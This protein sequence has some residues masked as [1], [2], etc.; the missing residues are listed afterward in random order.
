MAG[1]AGIEPTSSLLEIAILP[2]ELLLYKLVGLEGIEPPR[3]TVHI[4]Y[5]RPVFYMPLCFVRPLVP[6]LCLFSQQPP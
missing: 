6:C 1:C 3:C 4:E 5:S 2:I